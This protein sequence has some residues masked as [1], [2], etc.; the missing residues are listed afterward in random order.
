MYK[1]STPSWDFGEFRVVIV[2]SVGVLLKDQFLPNK[3]DSW[4]SP[5]F[6]NLIC[7]W[8]SHSLRHLPTHRLR[9]R[10]NLR[11]KIA[12]AILLPCIRYDFHKHDQEGWEAFCSLIVGSHKVTT[13]GKCLKVY[14]VKEISRE[15]FK[16]GL[17]S[18]WWT[19]QIIL[20]SWKS[21]TWVFHSSS[22]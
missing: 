22:C 5:S 19:S 18:G 21:F 3:H 20:M 2:L 12:H 4:L 17:T 9:K 15:T 16:E 11:F 7:G 8:I 10:R 6:G 13:L 14:M 1:I